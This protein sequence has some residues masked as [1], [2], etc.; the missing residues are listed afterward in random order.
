MQQVGQGGTIRLTVQ[1]QDGSGNLVNPLNPLVSIYN[2]SNAQVVAN[3]TPTNAGTGIYFYDYTVAVAAPL[4][5]W[6][7]RFTGT[8]N[9]ASVQ[10]DDEFLVVTAGSVSPYSGQGLLTLSEY[11]TFIGIDPSNTR[12]DA[13]TEALIAAASNAVRTYTDREFEL[14]SDP[15]T[16][17]FQYDNS[18]FLEIDDCV[19]VTT[20]TTDAG[21]IGQ[22][23]ALTP[24][25]WTAMP[26]REETDDR[27]FYYLVVHGGPY[28]PFSPQ[29]GFERNLDKFDPYYRKNPLVS[30]TATWGWPLIPA[31]VKLATAWMIEDTLSSPQ[32]PTSESI[33]GYARSWGS[34]GRPLAI[35]NRSRDLLASYQRVYG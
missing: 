2:P 32:G 12:D 20:I 15:A 14:S 11:K 22:S 8:I 28:F 25:Q 1:Y 5:Q 31:D 29:M 27:P 13:Q 33:E 10:G 24:E 17:I 26:H 19:A 18:G 34:G 7:G 4:G 16:R 6:Y 30:V 35:P 9:G 23:Y 21:V 3:A